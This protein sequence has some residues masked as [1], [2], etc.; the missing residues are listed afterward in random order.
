MAREIHRS[1]VF[2]RRR[3]REDRRVGPTAPEPR[4]RTRV[5]AAAFFALL[6]LVVAGPTHLR[7]L[8][9]R[10]PLRGW[11]M[12][13]DVADGFIDARFLQ[14]RA[15]GELVELDPARLLPRERPGAPAV[16]PIRQPAQLAAVARGLCRVLGPDADVRVVARRATADGWVPAGDADVDLCRAPGAAP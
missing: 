8:A 14:R 16:R 3:I 2:F 12:Y 7:L 5:R 13:R 10:A 4:W 1:K 11:A 9:P 6:A 15:D